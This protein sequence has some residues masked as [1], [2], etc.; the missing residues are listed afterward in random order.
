MDNQFYEIQLNQCYSM[1]PSQLKCKCSG[2]VLTEKIKNIIENNDSKSSSLITTPTIL[3]NTHGNE[4]CIPFY[5]CTI[6]K[7]ICHGINAYC[8]CDNGTWVSILCPKE[9]LCKIQD[10]D[11]MTTCQMVASVDDKF[12]LSSMSGLAVSITIDKY[13][14]LFIVC[15]LILQ[16]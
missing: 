13:F 2:K 8:T 3:S 16:K 9:K 12:S 4:I 10:T 14:H 6:G 15:L 7:N 5:S 11:T 1:N